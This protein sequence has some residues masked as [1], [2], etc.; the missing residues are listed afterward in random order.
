MN[1]FAKSYKII[2]R[3]L[4]AFYC[5]F[6][7]SQGMTAAFQVNNR[8]LPIFTIY[9]VDNADFRVH[10]FISD[11]GIVQFLVMMNFLKSSYDFF[12]IQ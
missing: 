11:L 3:I 1:L 7:A 10:I 9:T 4:I 12:L 6:L 2:I 8:L 5:V